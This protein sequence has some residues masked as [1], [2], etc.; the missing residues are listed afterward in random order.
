MKNSKSNTIIPVAAVRPCEISS[1]N[2]LYAV[3]PVCAVLFDE[4]AFVHTAF[5]QKNL[6]RPDHAGE[7]RGLKSEFGLKYPPIGSVSIKGRPVL[8][9]K[10]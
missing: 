6:S 8:F 5:L 9:Q 4:S 1:D 10:S 7:F 3:S 2:G